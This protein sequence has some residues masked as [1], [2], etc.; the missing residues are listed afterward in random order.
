MVEEIWL[1]KV[2]EGYREERV[3]V[4]V[5]L[6]VGRADLLL[7]RFRVHLE[8]D[9]WFV[10]GMCGGFPLLIVLPTVVYWRCYIRSVSCR[11]LSCNIGVTH[12][13]CCLRCWICEVIVVAQNKTMS[14][15]FNGTLC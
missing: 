3:A 11:F 15:C 2:R 12:R 8:G 9:V 5:V 10:L 7:S 6:F 1:V 13:T 14:S 4:M